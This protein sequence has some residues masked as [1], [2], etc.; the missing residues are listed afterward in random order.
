MSKLSLKKETPRSYYDIQKGNE[1]KFL[2]NKLMI[3]FLVMVIIYDLQV[4][5]I[6]YW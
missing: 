6:L 2:S 1:F 5:G 4:Q 3:S